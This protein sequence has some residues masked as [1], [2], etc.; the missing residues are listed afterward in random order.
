L[1][2]ENY[3]KYDKDEKV[4]VIRTLSSRPRY[5]GMLMKELKENRIPKNE[6]TPNEAPA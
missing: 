3:P 6:V 2:V 1:L 5:G 4:E